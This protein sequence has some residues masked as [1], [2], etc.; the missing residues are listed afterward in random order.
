[1]KKILIILIAVLIVIIF[2]VVHV[3][4]GD[5][6]DDFYTPD[7][8][9]KAKPHSKGRPADSTQGYSFGQASLAG[10][11]A[12]K[13]KQYIEKSREYSGKSRNVNDNSYSSSDEFRETVEYYEI[14]GKKEEI[15][16][17]EFTLKNEDQE[18]F[19]VFQAVDFNDTNIMYALQEYT[20]Y[21]KDGSTDYIFED[22]LLDSVSEV[23]QKDKGYELVDEGVVATGKVFVVID[24]GDVAI[25][26]LRSTDE[27]SIDGLVDALLNHTQQSDSIV[28]EMVDFIEFLMTNDDLERAR[29]AYRSQGKILDGFTIRDTFR[30]PPE[31]TL[32]S[33]ESVDLPFKEGSYGPPPLNG[34]SMG[35]S[36]NPSSPT[37]TRTLIG[38]K[39]RMIEDPFPSSKGLRAGETR[40][41]FE[42][43]RTDKEGELVTIERFAVGGEEGRK[44][45]IVSQEAVFSD[46]NV[47][48]A[49]QEYTNYFEDGS[50]DYVFKDGL[51]DSISEKYQKNGKQ[52]LADEGATAVGGIF[53][54]INR[55]GVAIVILRS[56][57]ESSIDIG[58]Y[59]V[60]IIEF[61]T[62]NGDLE[63][64]RKAYKL[65]GKRLDGFTF[66][67][68]GGKDKPTGHY[69]DRCT[70]VCGECVGEIKSVSSD[71][72]R[73]FDCPDILR[74]PDDICN[75]QLNAVCER[76]VTGQCGWTKTKEWYRC[77]EDFRNGIL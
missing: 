53:V 73:R 2:A 67:D 13:Q 60:P 11:L 58:G 57:D 29:E 74:F 54:N 34:S 5:H 15:A 70:N 45:F 21:F 72:S 44:G 26:I 69:Y 71:D 75:K 12:V 25:V 39:E 24:R 46:A 63:R 66:P 55:R 38:P 64:I 62:E 40:N 61:L 43:Y 50:L 47:M 8:T 10:H 4:S 16:V 68:P 65:R 23:Y 56:T 42:V 3:M 31:I 32:P 27:S 59:G 51:L 18:R 52:R 1:M 20:N 41:R 17:V 36:Y 22:E 9:K 35:G 76:Q 49:L 30:N 28:E 77:A 19:V 37:S 7:V 6:D 48:Y 33:I 14:D